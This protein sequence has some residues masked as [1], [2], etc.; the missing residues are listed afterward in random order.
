MRI[1]VDGTSCTGH[2][3]CYSMAPD[4]LACDEEGYVTIRDQTIEVPDNQVEAAA[5]A[6]GT[7]PEGAITLS[8]Q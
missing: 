8:A 7:C 1:T 2:G 3:R 5:D 6:E 4:L